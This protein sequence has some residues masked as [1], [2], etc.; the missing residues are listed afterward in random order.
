MIPF[1]LFQITSNGV[2]LAGANFTGCL[3]LATVTPARSFAVVTPRRGM[4]TV[5]PKRE[6]KPCQ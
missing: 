2:D 6:I 1:F 3:S 5:T 4:A